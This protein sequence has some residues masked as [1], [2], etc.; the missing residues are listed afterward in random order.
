MD[1]KDILRILIL[2]YEGSI[3][4][5][6][7]SV[8]FLCRGLAERGH[9]VVLGCKKDSLYPELLKNDKVK[10]IHLPFSS[11]WD[12]TSIK[13]IRDIVGKEKINLINAQ[14][15]YDR[16]L[17]IFAKWIYKLPIKLVHTRR[18][19][20]L[21]IGGIQS[22]LYTK[23]T[24]QVVAVSQGVKNALVKKGF[25]DHHVTVIHNGTPAEKYTNIEQKKVTLLKQRY[26]LKDT[27]FVV[28][29]V[30]RLKKQIQ[31]FESLKF[32]EHQITVFFVGITAKDIGAEKNNPILS[33][34]K[35]HFCGSIE[36]KEV[37][38]YYKL[39]N[40]YVL[41]STTE[42][43]SQAILEAMYLE[44]PVI[45]TNAGGNPDLIQHGKNGFLFE[46]GDIKTLAELIT[47]VKENN[48][49]A[50]SLSEGSKQTAHIDFSINRTIDNYEKLFLKLLDKE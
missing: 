45:T 20:P 37:L 3:A 2:T 18:Q 27:D 44:L 9:H 26:N 21:S 16:Y 17:S 31:L 6:T 14:A 34:H 40:L 19:M 33:H 11:K 36:P 47:K 43:L 15:S 49:L 25:P 23:G 50:K 32:I 7:M 29:S 12:F 35:V 1:K 8:S 24:D 39:F 22:W 28:G 5:S 41:P 38:Y 10:I 42:G 48:H 46:D 4:G 30:S 13:N